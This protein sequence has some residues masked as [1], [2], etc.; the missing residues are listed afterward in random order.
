M[1]EL[2]AAYGA[3]DDA[4]WCRLLGDD[5]WYVWADAMVRDV[6][7]D[8]ETFAR[9]VIARYRSRRALPLPQQCVSLPGLY[10]TVVLDVKYIRTLYSSD[11]VGERAN[12]V[13]SCA[14]PG[15]ELTSFRL[16]RSVEWISFAHNPAI[17]SIG[18]D[19]LQYLNW[20]RSVDLSGLPNLTTVGNGMCFRC[21]GLSCIDL[22]PLSSI[23]A[24]GNWFL[25]GCDG[26]TSIDLSPL[27][28][29]RAIGS[30]FLFGCSGLT[31]IDLSPIVEY[32]GDRCRLLGWLLWPNEHQP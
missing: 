30:Q 1:I 8:V 4:G 29:T 26:L 25:A 23:T 9:D 22:C 27:S 14:A 17:T 7:A 16:A 5:V 32:H 13:L 21:S 31:S 10:R 28:N 18:D 12:V 2:G 3:T 11:S 24:V 20:I 6:D 19:F 15:P